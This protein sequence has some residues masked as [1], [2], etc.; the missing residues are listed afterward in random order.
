MCRCVCACAFVCVR[1]FV[2]GASALTDVVRS[3]RSCNRASATEREFTCHVQCHV[4]NVSDFE[5]DIVVSN[6]QPISNIGP[7]K[8]QTI[9]KE[10]FRE[11]NGNKLD[12]RLLCVSKLRLGYD[13]FLRLTFGSDFFL[14]FWN[15]KVKDQPSP[16]FHPLWMYLENEIPQ[17]FSEL[18]PSHGN[19]SL[20]NYQQSGSAFVFTCG[21]R[22]SLQKQNKNGK[23]FVGGVVTNFSPFHCGR[24][25]VGSGFQ[26][27]HV[28]WF[29]WCFTSLK[30]KLSLES[31]FMWLFLRLDTFLRLYI[32]LKII[33]EPL[34]MS[35]HLKKHEPKHEPTWSSMLLRQVH[36]V[37][38]ADDSSC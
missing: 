38:A 37:V 36:V 22:T 3:L 7:D 27:F 33:L 35:A 10:I 19:N 20:W 8:S 16:L 13:V 24:L 4:S 21:S 30:P 26:K 34:L 11:Q 28:V 9:F 2:S 17:A 5:R 1:L 23:A 12:T 29:S 15:R 18:G 32:L 6:H 25:C 14:T 31:T